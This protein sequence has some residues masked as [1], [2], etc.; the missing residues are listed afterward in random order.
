MARGEREEFSRG[1]PEKDKTVFPLVV[2][3]D[4]AVSGKYDLED[5]S[6]NARKG[7]GDK[8]EEG[9]QGVFPENFGMTPPAFGFR[10][11]VEEDEDH[12]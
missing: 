11:G 1:S 2:K 5:V 9:E 12:P 10:R 8:N 7:D 3:H 4:G 6:E